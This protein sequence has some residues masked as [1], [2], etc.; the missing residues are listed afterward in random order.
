M[1]I[2]QRLH[3]AGFARIIVLDGAE[4][5]HSDA[6][7]IILALWPYEAQRETTSEG[8]QIH[9][10][11][12]ASQKA[13]EAAA[14]IAKQCAEGGAALRDDIRVK[15]IFARLP[16]FTQGRNTLSYVEEYGSRF[17]VQ[18]MTTAGKL[19]PTHHLQEQEHELHCGQ[20]RRCIDACPTNALENGIFHRER[21][22]RNWMM[23]GQPVPEQIR[24]KMGNMLIGCDICQRVC[25][26]NTAPAG[27]PADA[28]ALS[29]LLSLP[30]ETAHSLRP[31]I[32]ANLSIPNRVLS[33]ACLLAG[34]SGNPAYLPQLE[35][36]QKHPSP[37]V[38]EHAEWAVRVL[39]EK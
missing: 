3:D 10:Y 38:A 39:K 23:N 11:Y 33:Q 35:V 6:G 7:S 36:L 9:P 4:C 34:C 28:V 26:H 32:G 14:A 12:Y 20:C 27:E 24:A 37:A 15:P 25:P 22:L 13:Y 29:K 16:G 17:H 19:P 8:A 21:C 31:L 18:I 5:G 2:I 1:D 30:K